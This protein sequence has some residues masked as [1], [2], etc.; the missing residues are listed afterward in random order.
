MET[1]L[2]LAICALIFSVGA[3]IY[4]IWSAHM[5]SKVLKSIMD[6]RNNRVPHRLADAMFT[7]R[8]EN[9]RRTEGEEEE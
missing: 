5:A 3:L 6:K 2:V 7:Q 8:S 9:A 4:V 1:K